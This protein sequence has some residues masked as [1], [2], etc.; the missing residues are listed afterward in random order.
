MERPK[1]KMNILV[2]NITLNPK[3][4]PLWHQ[5]HLALQW[6]PEIELNPTFLISKSLTLTIREIVKLLA[7]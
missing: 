7:R 6:N 3:F 1:P 4:V 2:Q 5:I